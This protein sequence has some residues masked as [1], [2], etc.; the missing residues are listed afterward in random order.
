MNSDKN[1]FE[2][3]PTTRSSAVLSRRGLLGSIAAVAGG[4]A[5]GSALWERPLAAYATTPALATSSP[6]G[7]STAMYSYLWNRRGLTSSDL[8]SGQ[9]WDDTWVETPETPPSA[10]SDALGAL[11]SAT[12]K[13][14]GMVSSEVSNCYAAFGSWF[15]P[16]DLSNSAYPRLYDY[17]VQ[18]GIPLLWS[19]QHNPWTGGGIFD[20]SIGTWSDLFNSSTAVYKKFHGELDLLAGGMLAKL[21]AAGVPVIIIPFSEI[22]SSAHWY[23][24][25]TA[26]D[27]IALYQHFV[28]YMLGKGLKN[29]IFAHEVRPWNSSWYPG[30]AYV[31]VISWSINGPSAISSSDYNAGSARNKVLGISQ[32]NVVGQNIAGLP[33]TLTSSYPNIN[34]VN[35]WSNSGGGDFAI[36]DQ[37]N[38]A[39]FMSDSHI[40][41]RS[42]TGLG[43]SPTPTLLSYPAIPPADLSSSAA[44]G[45]LSWNWNSDGN[46]EGWAAAS[47]DI[48]GIRALNRRLNVHQ[49]GNTNPGINGPTISLNSSNSVLRIRIMNHSMSVQAAVTWRQQGQSNWQGQTWTISAADSDWVVYTVDL[50]HS[51]GWGGTI[52]QLAIYPMF[53]SVAVG[54]AEIDYFTFAAS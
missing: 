37:T 46:L 21:N 23:E 47:T 20:T 6:L 50:S 39:T 49:W 34:F 3:Q 53:T 31:D 25:S 41:N 38:F 1:F 17:Y 27:F 43:P 54:S 9:Y 16:A 7:A 13:W 51:P 5:L 22:G 44:P 18:G 24:R 15:T 11:N 35:F 2:P 10:F 42:N 48:C 14:P 40:V 26:A 36:V 30:D 33:G 8:V 12:G 28:T 45:T 19:Q 4:V 52:E 32:Y 29:L